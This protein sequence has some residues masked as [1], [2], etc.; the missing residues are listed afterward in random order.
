[1][2]TFILNFNIVGNV[3]N[4]GNIGRGIYLHPYAYDANRYV[5]CDSTPGVFYIRNCPSGLVFDSR[6]QVCN[7]PSAYYYGK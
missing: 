4:L 2:H 7:Y 3:C 6:F 1:M 5:Q